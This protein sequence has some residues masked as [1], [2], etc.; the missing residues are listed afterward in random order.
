MADRL[1]RAITKAW[2][3]VFRT[4]EN[5]DTFNEHVQEIQR[6]AQNQAEL[7]KSYQEALQKAL[8]KLSPS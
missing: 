8:M 6:R 1:G 5:L 4:H 3:V 7:Q 2:Q